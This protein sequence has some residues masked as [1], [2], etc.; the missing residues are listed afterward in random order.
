M[1]SEIITR[2]GI[3]PNESGL[4]FTISTADVREYLQAKMD[5]ICDAMAKQGKN[6]GHIDIMVYSPET[7]GRKFIPFT[8]FLPTDIL[9]GKRK[10]VNK[11]EPSIF[12]PAVE[13]K[14]VDIIQPIYNLLKCYTYSS[15]DK[16]AFERSKFL[17]RELNLS[18]N[19]LYD[20]MRYMT[21]KVVK[22]PSSKYELVTLL[23]DPIRV[24]HDMLIMPDSK[25]D[26]SI[27]IESCQKI[28]GNEYNY[29]IIRTVYNGKNKN[30][31]GNNVAT[32]F[33]NMLRRNNRK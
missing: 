14:A 3:T 26:F 27:I 28:R 19:N 13:D 31:N 30:K 5:V 2:S 1:A 29:N 11:D 24:F 16:E 32:E 9:V 12:N 18:H 23:L 22:F 15:A 33:N 7:F 8:I 21:P 25:K 6:L 20:I 17:K 4:P 10:T